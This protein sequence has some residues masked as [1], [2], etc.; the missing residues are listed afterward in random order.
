MCYVIDNLD[1]SIACDIHNE[2]MKHETDKI[3]DETESIYWKLNLNDKF[4]PR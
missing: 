2:H 4:Y 1:D 3:Q